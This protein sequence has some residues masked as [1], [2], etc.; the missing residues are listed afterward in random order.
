MNH[1]DPSGLCYGEPPADLPGG[2]GRTYCNWM[3]NWLFW[4]WPSESAGYPT[5][6]PEDK[7]WWKAEAKLSDANDLL[8]RVLQG[9]VSSDCQNDLDQLLKIGISD[10]GILVSADTDDWNNAARNSTRAIGLFAKN[11]PDYA[12]VNPTLTI[13][14]MVSGRTKAVAAEPGSAL[15]GN[16]YFNPA[17]VNALSVQDAA[18]VLMHEVIHTLGPSD[19][20]I[21]LVLFGPNASKVGAA[22]DNITQKLKDDCFP[23]PK[24]HGA[25][26]P[27]GQ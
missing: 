24:G 13:S 14:Q 2:W 21:Q 11:S 22:S 20:L 12:N 27:G 17:Y 4:G 8:H 25:P 9:Q 16:I 15:D 19:E 5:D 26:G 7:T 18:A 3:Q 6:P 10:L 1:A 23:S